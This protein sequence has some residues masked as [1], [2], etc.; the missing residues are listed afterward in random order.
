MKL[1]QGIAAPCV[2][3]GFSVAGL[4][5][6]M[7]EP[8]VVVLLIF[9]PLK[10]CLHISC[11]STA[12]QARQSTHT[13]PPTARPLTAA[14]NTTPRAY[15]LQQTVSNT[16]A[17][18]PATPAAPSAPRCCIGPSLDSPALHAATSRLRY[19][20]GQTSADKLARTTR[21]QQAPGRHGVRN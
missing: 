17:Q 11:C 10:A 1:T 13:V 20:A 19:G 14:S 18:T 3:T 2:I 6:A 5:Q 9:Y 8:E 4:K 12:L 16:H 21:R 15:L 7:K